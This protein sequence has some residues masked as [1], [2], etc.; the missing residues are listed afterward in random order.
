MLGLKFRI[1]FIRNEFTAVF[2]IVFILQFCLKQKKLILLIDQILFL[3]KSLILFNK[4]TYFDENYF[5]FHKMINFCQIN[6]ATFFVFIITL[7]ISRYSGV[8]NFMAKFFSELIVNY[9]IVQYVIVLIFINHLFKV[10]NKNFDII[11]SKSS[12]SMQKNL[13]DFSLMHNYYFS[14]CEL[15]EK[16]SNFYELIMLLSVPYIFMTM[17]VFAYHAIKNAF[18]NPFFSVMPEFIHC[19]SKLLYCIILLIFITKSTT[20]VSLEVSLI[21]KFSFK[22]WYIDFLTFQEPENQENNL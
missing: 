8:M 2:S 6:M 10:V 9:A 20:E 14:L 3:R 4:K 22:N 11:L 18:V 17:L 7:E 12:N 13:I 21:K 1:A 16:V 19:L 5:S 15:S